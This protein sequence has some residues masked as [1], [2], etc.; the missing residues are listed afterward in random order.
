[1]S[2]AGAA[3]SSSISKSGQKGNFE[4]NIENIRT[5]IL[6]ARE[7]RAALREQFAKSGRDSLSISLNIPGYPKSLPLLFD[8]FEDTLQE[9]RLFLQAHGIPIEATHETR[10]TDEA[11]DFY[12]VPIADR[13]QLDAIKALTEI[14]ESNHPLGRIIDIDITDRHLQPVSSGKLKPCLMCVKPAIVCMR[15]ANHTNDELREFLVRS[16]RAYLQNKTKQRLCRHLSALA[17]RAILYEISASPK[18]GLV[19]RFEQGAHHDMDYFTFIASTSV[20]AGYFEELAIVG[21]DFHGDKVRDALPALRAI[22]LRMEAA[23]F[24]ATHGINTQKGLIFLIGLSLFAAAHDISIHHGFSPDR[25]R[26]IIISIC[27]GLVQNEL[28]PATGNEKTHGQ[29]CFQRYGSQGGGVRK[30]AEDG[31]PSVF[32]Q[33]LPELKTALAGTEESIAATQINSALIRTLMRLM[34]VTNDSNILYRADLQTLKTVQDMAQRV[35]DA[36]G[37]GTEADRY[38]QLLNYCQQTHVSPGGAADLLAVTV[39]LYFVEHSYPDSSK[40]ERMG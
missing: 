33:G 9:C 30:E 1:M 34:T 13:Q 16:I 26:K 15:E 4:L 40:R 28:I 27:T 7:K 5:L 18:P 37:T 12:Q 17:L 23:M 3:H 29:V 35:L 14:F 31:L 21:C 24:S 39:F 11:G 20:L 32:D 8:F 38:N 19:G 22:G 36:E 6:N 25:C 10:Q 2:A